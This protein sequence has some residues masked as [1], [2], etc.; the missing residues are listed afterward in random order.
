MKKFLMTVMLGISLLACSSLTDREKMYEN[1]NLSATIVTN[2]G[3]I[4]LFLYP[5]SAPLAVANFIYL[6]ESN[7]YDNLVF[8]RVDA[9]VIQSGD[10][11][12][13]GTGGAGYVVPDEFDGFLK[14]NYS[15]MVGMA[16]A[17][18]NTSSSQFFITK[19]ALPS[20]NDNYTAFATLKS[21]DDLILAKSIEVG[22]IIEDVII[23]GES[24]EEYLDRF[25]SHIEKWDA[26]RKEN[27]K[28]IK[29]L[30]KKLLEKK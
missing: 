22:D 5:T 14:F 1:Y 12:A 6:A 17:G 11:N 8:H 7:F 26:E 21:S 24:K 2:K 27:E 30:E 20:L 29:E 4:N 25:K 19:E 23:N 18:K 13:N 10:P 3:D 9:A 28:K 15:G 16:N